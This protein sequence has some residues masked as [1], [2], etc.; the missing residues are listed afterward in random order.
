MRGV[1]APPFS[2]SAYK[3]PPVPSWE[4]PFEKLQPGRRM[5]ALSDE[6]E[7]TGLR[8]GGPGC[9]RG[10]QVTMSLYLCIYI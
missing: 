10:P 2:G 3:A 9:P 1:A 4:H 5:A 7:R 6:S 8:W